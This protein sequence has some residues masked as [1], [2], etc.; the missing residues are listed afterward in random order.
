[1][2]ASDESGHRADRHRGQFLLASSPDRVPE[3][4]THHRR[5][6]WSLAV[7]DLPV[8]DLLDRQGSQVGW[9]LGHPVLD[10]VLGG[11]AIT[12]GTDVTTG[13]DWSAVDALYE[14]LAGRFLLVLLPDDEPTVLLDAYGSLAAVFSAAEQ[15]VASTPTLIGGEWDT[16]LLE[17]SGF[18]DRGTWLP[19]GLTL[20]RGV[21]RLPANHAL[22]LSTW[23]LQRCWSPTPPS[24]APSAEGLATV[25]HQGLRDTIAAVA[26]VHPLT[27][28]LTAGRDS[29]VLLACARDFLDRA[30][31][32]TLVPPG[33]PSVDAHLAGRLA[34]RFGLAH[35]VLPVVAPPAESLTGWLSVTGHAVGGELWRA[36]EALRRLDPGRVLLPGTAGEVGRGHTHRPGDPEDAP[37][38]PDRLLERLRLPGHRAYLE[39]AGSWLATLPDLPHE[40]VL[41]L[42]YIEQRLSCWAGPGHYGNQRSLFELAPFASR[43]LFRALLAA[44]LGYRRT[45]QLATD[46]CEIA[47][48]EL[49]DLPFNRFTGLRGTARRVVAKAQR[50]ARGMR[51]DLV[52]S[53]APAA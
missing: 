48:P 38:T 11:S 40:T 2:T 15:V 25:V 35:T 19:F 28:S 24:A 41:E 44:P 51:G 30:A 16:E 31:L 37:V 34:S 14:R 22:D 8:L 50:V 10:G 7:R 32:F 52:A 26:A 3:G 6:G 42:A 43:P 13:V 17:V 27:L 39:L 12:L 46:V 45:E 33:A 36:H 23:R 47:W 9:V 20:R 4:F 18:P 21:Q 53:T 49:L 29:R 1:M 5:A